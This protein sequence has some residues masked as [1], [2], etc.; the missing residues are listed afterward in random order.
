MSK[1]S[2]ILV[3]IDKD[4]ISLTELKSYANNVGYDEVKAFHV[5]DPATYRFVELESD[6]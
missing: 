1:L 2:N 4:H 6:N 5:E 3:E